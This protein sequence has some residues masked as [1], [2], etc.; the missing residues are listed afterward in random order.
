MELLKN[1]PTLAN[2]VLKPRFLNV[3]ISIFFVSLKM[4]F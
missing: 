4:Y 2:F 1:V 3:F